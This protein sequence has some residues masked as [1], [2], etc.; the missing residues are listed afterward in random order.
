MQSR[1]RCGPVHMGATLRPENLTIKDVEMFSREIFVL[2]RPLAAFKP[3]EA[4][5]FTHGPP[6]TSPS[7]SRGHRPVSLHLPRTPYLRATQRQ[8]FSARP[9]RSVPGSLFQASDGAP[10][11]WTTARALL[12]SLAASS[13][14]VLAYAY[15]TGDVATAQKKKL[16]VYG[17][18]A[19]LQKA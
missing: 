11:T 3:L 9:R 19:D 5:G 16:P 14:V 17:Q 10:P 15:L 2:R 4:A 6:I 12:L 13:A 7:S 18:T 8:A 1:A